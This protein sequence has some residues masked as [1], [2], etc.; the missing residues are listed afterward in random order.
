LN[1]DLA[2]AAERPGIDV[3]TSGMLWISG[4]TFAMGFARF[5]QAPARA[6]LWRYRHGAPSSPAG[7]D[8]ESAVRVAD[9]DAVACATWAGAFSPNAYGGPGMIATRWEW[10]SDWHRPRHQPAAMA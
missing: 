5:T 2:G 10:T 4:G 3:M 6:A 7:L 1:G 8:N 9:G